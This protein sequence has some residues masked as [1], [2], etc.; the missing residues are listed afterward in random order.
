MTPTQ[1]D[2]IVLDNLYV[3]LIIVQK[4]V[5]AKTCKIILCNIYK[6]LWS[7]SYAKV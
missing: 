5:T 4:K 2:F 6:R 3:F 1:Q 7:S